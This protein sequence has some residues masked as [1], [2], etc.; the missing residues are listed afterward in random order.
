[1]K[2]APYMYGLQKIIILQQ[3]KLKMLYR[4][5]WRPNNRF[6]FLRHFDFGQNLKNHFPKGIFQ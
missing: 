4:S 5:K 3:Q 2:F 6:L 1:M